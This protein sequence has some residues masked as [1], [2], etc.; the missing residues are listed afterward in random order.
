MHPERWQL[1]APKLCLNLEEIMGG[2]TAGDLGAEERKVVSV[3][4]GG[5]LVTAASFDLRIMGRRLAAEERAE[6][7][8][9]I[10]TP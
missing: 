9:L 2:C 7:A 1:D 5:L 10:G 4:P 6:G 8:E 3:D